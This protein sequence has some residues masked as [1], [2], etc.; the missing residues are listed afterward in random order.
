MD[1]LDRR[2]REKYDASVVPG[3]F[4]YMPENFRLGISGPVDTTAEG[5]KRLGLALD[6]LRS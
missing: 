5:L 1:D 3:K 4:F 6:E 2:L